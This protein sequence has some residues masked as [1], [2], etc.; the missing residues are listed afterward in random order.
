[1]V[2]PVLC[3]WAHG[4]LDSLQGPREGNGPGVQSG[5]FKWDSALRH[6]AKELR[7]RSTGAATPRDLSP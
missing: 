2:D 1:M 4:G 7:R 6:A 5:P 3:S